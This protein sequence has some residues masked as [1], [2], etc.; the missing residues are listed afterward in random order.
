MKK[1]LL[2]DDEPEILELYGDTLE[3]ADFQVIKASNGREC[4][5]IAQK[6]RPDLVLLDLKMPEIDGME[7]FSTMKEMEETKNI[8]VVF[9]TAFGDP[10]SIETDIKMAKEIGAVDFIK[11]G[12]D[13][14]ELV[15]KVRDIVGS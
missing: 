13:L 3:D 4:I 11:K 7:A 8:K 2:V 6:E 9:L 5:D 15:L 10:K 1:I 12:I 14:D